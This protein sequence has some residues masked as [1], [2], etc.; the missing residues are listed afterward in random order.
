M[1]FERMSG[2]REKI[3]RADK[4]IDEFKAQL[5]IFID[6]KPYA[7]S[8]DVD[9]DPA[10]PIVHILK[11]DAI[12]PDL[13]PIVGDAIH[14]FRSALDYLA[15]EL[16]RANRQPV[17]EKTEFPILNSPITT[18]K[19]EARFGTKVQGMRKEVID[20]IRSIHPYQGGNNT[21][22][23]LHRLDVIDKHNT[24]LAGLGNITGV[25][26]GPPLGDQW[27]GNKW[28]SFG[29]PA[30]LEKGHKFH[31]SGLKVDK[32][33]PFFAEVV[34]NQPDVAEGYPVILGLAQ[35]RKAVMDVIG[36]LSWALR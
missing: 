27:N 19:L 10:K 5:R 33:T 8:V 13:M 14:N 7:V 3:K 35:F 23:R 31:F 20:A 25:S 22:W 36:S 32:S 6:S 4:H 1:A 9:T 29:A 11:A 28:L 34:F 18:S 17:A 15:C 26:G 12:P 21:L 24:L 16:V 2:I 30:I